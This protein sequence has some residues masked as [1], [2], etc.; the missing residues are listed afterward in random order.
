M[1][2]ANSS[3]SVVWYLR[4]ERPEDKVSW[5]EVL[6][7]YK[8]E[9]TSTDSISL[10]RHDSTVS[11][12]SN[13]LS[14]VERG[15]L[16][17]K[18]NEIETCHGIL[19]NQIECL[20]R[21]FDACAVIKQPV[22]LGNGLSANDFKGEACQFKATTSELVANLRSCIEFVGHEDEILRR[23]LD[24]ESERRRKAEEMLKTCREELDKSKKVSL[25]GPDLEV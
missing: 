10:R 12:Q 21:Y 22:E 16:Q 11:L 3:N 24:K 20:Q 9:P 23:K 6:Q 17:E 7:S 18:I 4:A 25:L 19:Q 14:V 8:E 2:N 5:V 13:T 15:N 1:N